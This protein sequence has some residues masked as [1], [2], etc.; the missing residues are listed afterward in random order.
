MGAT[1]ATPRADGR[2]HAAVVLTACLEG[3]VHFA[4]SVG[5]ALLRNLERPP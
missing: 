3:T 1:V 2:P 5:S 4:A